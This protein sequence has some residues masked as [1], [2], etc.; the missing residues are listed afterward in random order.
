M[1][2][3]IHAGLECSVINS[4]CPGLDS[5]SIGPEMYDIH[6]TGERLSISS[7]NRTY[8]FVKHLLGIIR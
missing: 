8:D 2:T 3:A 1:I 7:T 5:V 4:K 6:S